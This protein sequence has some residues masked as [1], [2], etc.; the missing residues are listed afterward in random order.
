MLKLKTLATGSSGNCYLLSYN[1]QTLILDCG[2]PIK[3][4][5]K[6]LNFNVSNVVG[7]LC[8]H[9]HNDHCRSLLDFHKMGIRNVYA[10]TEV[11]NGVT[12]W[13]LGDF[14]IT[15]FDLPHNGI[16]NYGFY[17][18]ID[19]QKILYMTDFEYCKYSFKHFEVNHILIECNY[20]QELVDRDL[21]NYEHKIRGHCSLNTCKG[22]I[23][24]NKSD[25]LNTVL[26]LHMGAATCNPMECVEQIQNIVG[27]NVYVD[28]AREGLEIE[29]KKNACPF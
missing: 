29:L 4:I 24:V 5:K 19:G 22:F 21:P 23:Q 27:D 25:F 13:K 14:G 11:S 17:I 12:N 20:Q 3:E 16:P 6:G 26:L 10:P 9:A 28:Y 1:E 15:C 18:K 7:V 2:I 8:T